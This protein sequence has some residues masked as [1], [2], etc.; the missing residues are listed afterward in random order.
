MACSALSQP[1][2]TLSAAYGFSIDDP[3]YFRLSNPWD[4]KAGGNGPANAMTFLSGGSSLVINAGLSWEIS[5][6]FSAG[7]GLKMV[8]FSMSDNHRTGEIVSFGPVFRV[9]FSSNTRK[10]VPFVEAAAY[11]SNSH[12]QK[13]EQATSGAQT[14]PAFSAN[15]SSPIG[16]HVLFGVEFKVSKPMGIILQSGLNGVMPPD[17]YK[18]A[19]YGVY[20]NPREYE[21]GWFVTFGGGLKYYFGRG[22]K[23][24]DF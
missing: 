7:L 12:S 20:E 2:F 22:E 21:G 18:G 17:T 15:A 16:L 19:D 1:S 23:K 11:L 3:D 13:Q 5:E 14:Q 9:N 6:Y 10:V 4:L 8:N 24:R